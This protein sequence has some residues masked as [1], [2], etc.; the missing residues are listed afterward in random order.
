MQK[1]KRLERDK[2][3]LLL[4]TSWEVCNKIGGI[5]TVLSTKARVLQ[6]KF[7]DKL[8]FIYRCLD[9]R[10]SVTLFH[11]AQNSSQASVIAS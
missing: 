2:I 5:Y 3:G 4:E 8:V 7:G 1:V 11:R 10:H 6:E 9:R